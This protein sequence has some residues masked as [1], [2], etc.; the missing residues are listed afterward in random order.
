MSF[1][2]E[3]GLQSFVAFYN[4]TLKPIHRNIFYVEKNTNDY[5]SVE[6][7]LQYVDDISARILPFANNIYN[8]EGGTHVTGFKTALTRT[9][10]NY[11]RKNNLIKES[12]DNFT[13]ED[14][15]EGLTAVISVKIREI[16]FEGQTKAKLGTVEARGMVESIFGDAFDAFLEEN[17]DDAR[18]IITKVVLALKARKAAKAAKDSVLRKGAL[19]GFACLENWPIAKAA[20][21]PNRNCLLSREIRPE[22]PPKWDVTAGLRP[23]FRFAERF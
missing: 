14:V 21:Q 4:R 6:I 13:G 1:Y 17:P 23:S 10:N 19:E 20:T 9:L 11:G 12:E 7:A 15:L 8:S 22:V 2:F 16:Q 3:G 18:A 5:E